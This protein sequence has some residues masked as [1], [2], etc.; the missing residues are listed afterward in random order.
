MYYLFKRLRNLR[1]NNEIY[2]CLSKILQTYIA[3][4][5]FSVKCK[6]N[7]LCSL[8]KLQSLKGWY[9]AS[10]EVKEYGCNKHGFCDRIL[11]FLSFLVPTSLYLLTVG[12]E[13]IAAPDRTIGHT[14]SVRLVYTRYWPF[15]E[16][17]TCTTHNIPKRQ[18]SVHSAGFKPRNLSKQA[19]ADR[20]TT[21][22]GPN[23]IRR[24][25]YL[26]IT[27]TQLSC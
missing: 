9:A 21:G 24:T 25:K 27:L 12:V 18:T 13:V 14:H 22:I 1:F 11:P 6:L 23:I 2:S 26:K 10:F 5:L 17:C 15:A 16:T 8:D 7:F 4:T 19:T 20:V 3:L